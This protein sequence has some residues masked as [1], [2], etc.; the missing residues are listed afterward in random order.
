[1]RR[2]ICCPYFQSATRSLDL[3]DGSYARLGCASADFAGRSWLPV[4]TVVKESRAFQKRRR[5]LVKVKQL[6]LTP[7]PLVVSQRTGQLSRL[8]AM[9]LDSPRQA[10]VSEP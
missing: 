9:V 3:V 5:P 4:A 6:V 2:G 1:M 8:A 7:V 10:A